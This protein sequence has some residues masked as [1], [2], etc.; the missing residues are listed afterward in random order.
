VKPAIVTARFGEVAAGRSFLGFAGAVLHRG[1]V[2][3]AVAAVADLTLAAVALAGGAQALG[4]VSERESDEKRKRCQGGDGE[5]PQPYAD[6]PADLRIKKA[7]TPVCSE[8]WPKELMGD[9]ARGGERKAEGVGSGWRQEAGYGDPAL[10]LRQARR[11]AAALHFQARPSWISR[12]RAMAD[13]AGPSKKKT[14]A[15]GPAFEMPRD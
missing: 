9:A 3:V 8:V 4:G 6:W 12:R 14:P 15:R 13:K 5:A 11:R 10:Q 1:I 2:L 7:T